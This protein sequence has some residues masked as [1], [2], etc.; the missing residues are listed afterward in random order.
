MKNDL[1]FYIY[2]KLFK[3]GKELKLN[4]MYPIIKYFNLPKQQKQKVKTLDIIY[5]QSKLTIILFRF[6]IA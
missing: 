3:Y 5:N 2:L 6:K 1:L 4:F